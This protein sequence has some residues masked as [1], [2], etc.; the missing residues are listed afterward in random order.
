MKSVGIDVSKLFFDVALLSGDE[1]YITDRFSNDE[2]GFKEFDTWISSQEALEAHFC[3]EATGSYSVNLAK[4][5]YSSGYTVSVENAVKIKGFSKSL[6]LRAK[7]DRIDAKL[8]A[9]YCLKIKPLPWQPASENREKLSSMTH[10]LRT[11]KETKVQESNRLEKTSPYEIQQQIEAHIKF[12]DEQIS[13]LMK[14]IKS[15]ISSDFLLKTQHRLLT[16]IPGIGEIVSATLLAEI[17]FKN[18]KQARQV[19]SHAGLTPRERQSGSSVRYKSHI[20]RMGNREIRKVLYMPVLCAKKHNPIIQEFW[21]RLE[22]KGKPGKV[23]A[24]A[25]MRKL[26]HIAVG[27]LKTNTE[28]TSAGFKL[29]G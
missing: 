8:I 10:R 18:Y 11:L 14:M 26:L 27:V 19:A 17:E 5:L 25:S 4:F 16:S 6:L 23:I 13:A 21:E 29:R 2:I 12:I 9:H 22:K 1:K 3:M 15:L 20:S 28:F 24:V 7:N